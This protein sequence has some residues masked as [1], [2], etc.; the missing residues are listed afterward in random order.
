MEKAEGESRKKRPR[1]FPVEIHL[2]KKI[3]Q[4]RTS[5]TSPGEQNSINRNYCIDILVGFPKNTT[6]FWGL[7]R[8]SR[9]VSI[10]ERNFFT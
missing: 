10:V 8:R 2:L 5:S 9:M 6:R 7:I 4:R 3:P 1:L